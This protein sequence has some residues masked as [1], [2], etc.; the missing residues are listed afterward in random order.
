MTD[1]KFK[2]LEDLF[3]ENDFAGLEKD[4]YGERYLKLC[5]MS[6]KKEMKELCTEYDIMIEGVRAK[7]YFVFLFKYS[8]LTI[9]QIDN[10]IS[11]KYLE[12]R[13]L[14]LVNEANLI[15]QLSRLRNFDWGGSFGNSLEKNIVDNYVKKIQSYERINEEIEGSLL[16]SLKGYTL[17]SW[18]NHWTSILIEDI[19]KDHPAVLPTIGLIKKVDFFLNNIPFDLK[20]TYFPQELMNEKLRIEGYRKELDSLKQKCEELKIAFGSEAEKQEIKNLLTEYSNELT[21]FLRDN[22]S[23]ITVLEGKCK[24]LGI[25]LPNTSD[26]KVLKKELGAAIRNFRD[27]IKL[28]ISSVRYQSEL[29]RIK[30]KCQELGILVPQ[31]LSDKALEQHLYTKLSEDRRQLAKDFVAGLKAS[32]KKIINEAKENPQELKQWLYENQGELRFDASNR[33]FLILTNEDEIYD[34]WKLKRNIHFLRDKIHRHLDNV[35]KQAKNL[36]TEFYWKKD[37]KTYQCKSDILFI[38]YGD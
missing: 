14:R 2:K 26:Q 16:T 25:A 4:E 5:A 8:A 21:Q 31:D 28:Y 27:K 34:S 11:K 1:K 38:K 22:R 23:N 13:K 37:K 6:R 30:N 12:Q 15:D 32:R 35:A 18:Y 20:V 33:F 7:N 3:R 19:F 24:E 36:E 29:T 10:F 9:A 17:N